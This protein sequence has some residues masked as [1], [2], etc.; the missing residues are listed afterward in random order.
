MNNQGE[1]L[2]QTRCM[3]VRHLRPT[4]GYAGPSIAQRLSTTPEFFRAGPADRYDTVK[5]VPEIGVLLSIVGKN[6][7]YI[8]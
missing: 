3:S 6:S 8:L 2:L 1:S 5:I 4:Q 7:A